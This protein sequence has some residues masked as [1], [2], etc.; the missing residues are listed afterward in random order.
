M[1]GTSGNLNVSIAF[2]ENKK[3]EFKHQGLNSKNSFIKI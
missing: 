1:W 3:E 2:Y